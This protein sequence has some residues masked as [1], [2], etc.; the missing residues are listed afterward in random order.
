MGFIT[1]AIKQ[2]EFRPM[3]AE[4][5]TYAIDLAVTVWIIVMFYRRQKRIENKCDQIIEILNKFEIDDVYFKVHE[6]PQEER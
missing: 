6:K 1:Y 3:F 2:P 5:I 4:L